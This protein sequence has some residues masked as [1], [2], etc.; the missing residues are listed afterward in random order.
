[1]NRHNGELVAVKTFNQMSLDDVNR[2]FGILKKAN[3]ENIVKLL[4]IEEDQKERSIV[5]VMELCT[6][7]SLFNILNDPE[8]HR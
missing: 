8:K 3:H 2:E 1:M 4:A 7:G 5:I 6:D